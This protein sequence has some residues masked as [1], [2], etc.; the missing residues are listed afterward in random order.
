MSEPTSAAC[1]HDPAQFVT[2]SEGTGY[3]PACEAAASEPVRE[4][5]TLRAYFECANGVTEKQA[6]AALDA[7]MAL[8]DQ[9]ETYRAALEIAETGLDN[10]ARLAE[11]NAEEPGWQVEVHR[12]ACE[13]WRQT[14]DALSA[15]ALSDSKEEK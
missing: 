3:C 14:K 1:A 12:I 4:A 5:E 11:L 7:L 9:A 15:P 8:A 6:L 13:C 2:A 10:I